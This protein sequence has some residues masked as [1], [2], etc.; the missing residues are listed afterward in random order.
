LLLGSRGDSLEIPERPRL[1]R[2]AEVLERLDMELLVDELHG[3]GPQARDLEQANEARRNLRP[4]PVVIGHVASRH[5]LG[6]LVADR[7]A[8]ARDLRRVAGPVRGDEV[9][10][11]APDRIGRPVVGDRLERDLA[12]DLEDVADLVEDPGEVAVGQVVAARRGV[13][14]GVVVVGVVEVGVCERR[15]I[16]GHARRW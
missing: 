13:V 16:V 15:G 10:R 11:A 3:L 9:D 5:E 4:E 2:L 14:R 12:L 1:R 7:L 8:D 6:G